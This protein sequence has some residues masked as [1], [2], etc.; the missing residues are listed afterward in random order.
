M[1]T[2]GLLPPQKAFYITGYEKTKVF[3]A[4]IDGFPLFSIFKQRTSCFSGNSKAVVIT[5]A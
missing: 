5:T 4:S 1:T 3:G 2:Y